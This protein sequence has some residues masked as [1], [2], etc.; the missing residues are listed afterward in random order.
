MSE[1]SIEAEY[2]RCGEAELL[3]GGPEDFG[4]FYLRNEDP[5]LAF[6]L[7]R[8]G[9]ADLAADLT[10]ET[11]ARALEGRL[12]FDASRGEPGAWL[13]GI[14]KHVLSESIRKGRVQ[15]AARRRIELERLELDDEA[16]VRIEGLTGE[17][18][19]KAL[20]R[21]QPEQRLAIEGRILEEKNY[22]EIAV[23]LRCSTSVVRQ[24]VSRGLRLLRERLEG[25]A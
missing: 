14:A 22:D 25:L 24:R 6:F 7:R 12:G 19:T 13:F 11:F 15:N 16:I 8:T 23:R 21:L 1:N 20:R 5:V 17:V 2:P 3:A 10:A 4:R 9:S 18:A